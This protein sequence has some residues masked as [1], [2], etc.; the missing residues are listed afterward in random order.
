MNSIVDSDVHMKDEGEEKVEER[1]EGSVTPHLVFILD[2]SGSMERIQEE[3]TASM[4]KFFRE[5]PDDMEVTYVTF[6]DEHTIHPK[7]P[8]KHYANASLQPDGCTALYDTLKAVFELYKDEQ[9]IMCVILTDG[10]DNASNTHRRE[11]NQHVTRLKKE[12]GWTF[13]FLG[14]NQDSFT[15][16]SSMGIN[17][18]K[19][20]SFDKAGVESAMTTAA[21]TSAKYYRAVTQK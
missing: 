20:F 14:A 19:D 8:A 3:T 6:S 10:Q 16:S 5:Q 7:K 13:L 15:E 9:Q 4:R 11:I 18:Y 2:T 12:K 17:D 21:T 1:V